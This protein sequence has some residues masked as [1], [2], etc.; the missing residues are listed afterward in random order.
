MAK[1]VV[2]EEHK[3]AMKAGRASAR[4]VDKYLNAIDQP[5]RRGRPVSIDELQRRRDDAKARAEEA[6]GTA[7]LKLLQ[8]ARDLE[9]R[10]QAE[11]ERGTV[12]V[13][14]LEADFVAAAATYSDSHGID[15]PTWREAGVPAEVLKAAGIKQ[16]R[17]RS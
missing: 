1:R 5:K 16:T 12:D 3:A 8:S 10:I 14:A 2:T 9:A 17:K 6:T 11:A 7:R 13:G 15:Y 4:A